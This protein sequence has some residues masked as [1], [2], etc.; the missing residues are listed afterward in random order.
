MAH[1]LTPLRTNPSSRSLAPLRTNPSSRS[2]TPPAAPSSRPN[3]SFRRRP[4]ST[5][6]PTESSGAAKRAAAL[7]P[8]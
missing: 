8:A 2:L 5:L 7:I 4:E 6:T 1:P 3:P